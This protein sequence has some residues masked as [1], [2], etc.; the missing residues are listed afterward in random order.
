M[1][2]DGL[3][4]C[5]WGRKGASQLPCARVLIMFLQWGTKRDNEVVPHPKRGFETHF[6]IHILFFRL[7]LG[8][9]VDA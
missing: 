8:C 1:Q 2:T 7:D 3:I 6:L 4:S 9:C 5:A